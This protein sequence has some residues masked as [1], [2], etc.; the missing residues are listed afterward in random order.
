MGCPVVA[1]NVGGIPEY[2]D[3]GVSGVL[4]RP[5]DPV[6]L[7]EKILLVLKN[8]SLREKIVKGGYLNAR[9]FDWRILAPQYVQLY[10][11]LINAN[12]EYEMI[13]NVLFNKM[14][15]NLNL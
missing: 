8:K 14:W 7:S 6:E 13:D 4:C 3:N 9:K 10:K 15:S 1:S 11:D 2:V 5:G 12:A